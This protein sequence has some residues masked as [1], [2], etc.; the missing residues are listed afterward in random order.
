MK[1][2]ITQKE[3][4][5]FEARILKELKEL[6]VW[7]KSIKVIV[8]KKAHIGTNCIHIILNANTTILFT[9]ELNKLNKNKLLI[10]TLQYVSINK[11]NLSIDFHIVE[12]IPSVKKLLQEE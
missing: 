2:K 4:K 7:D 12:N 9:D 3:M 5:K 11:N 6:Y 8:T 10:E 1:V